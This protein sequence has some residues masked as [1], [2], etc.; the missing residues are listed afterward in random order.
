MRLLL[1]SI[2]IT[3]AA[4][5][6]MAQTGGSDTLVSGRIAQKMKDTLSLSAQQKDSIYAVNMHLAGQKGI[7][8][9]Q[10][11]NS[12][13]LQYYIQRVERSR[14][15]LYRGVIGEEKYLLYKSKK[16]NLVNN[17]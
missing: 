9:Q 5:P 4:I 7:V 12:D 10:Y 17:N 8:R 3:V 2:F 16:R 11:S 15:S 13:S 1:L 14:D 6:A